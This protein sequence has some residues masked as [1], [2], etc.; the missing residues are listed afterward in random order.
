MD[1]VSNSVTLV[2][3]VPALERV[4]DATLS[5]KASFTSRPFSWSL[6]MKQSS[7]TPLEF[8]QLL[9]ELA[10]LLAKFV[11]RAVRLYRLHYIS[12]Y[13]NVLYH[14]RIPSS[15]ESHSLAAATHFRIPCTAIHRFVNTCA[16]L[17][18]WSPDLEIARA[19]PTV[20]VHWQHI[21]VAVDFFASRSLR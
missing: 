20:S 13:M 9:N 5:F 15:K 16:I 19:F 11:V 12:Q 3:I 17:V 6:R 7:V 8:Q 14:R 21:T 10:F 1:S 2:A 18:A 4:C